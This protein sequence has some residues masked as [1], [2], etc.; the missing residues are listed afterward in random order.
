MSVLRPFPSPVDFYST[1]ML[2]YLQYLLGFYEKSIYSSSLQNQVL[3]KRV[4]FIQLS[5]TWSSSKGHKGKLSYC[6]VLPSNKS[7]GK[8]LA[9]IHVLILGCTELVGED[10]HQ[11]RKQVN[12]LAPGSF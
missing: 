1:V 5:G 3:L 2:W 10:T 12:L 7:L 9:G 11:P 4:C 6:A 8:P